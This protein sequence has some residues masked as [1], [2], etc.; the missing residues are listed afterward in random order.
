MVLDPDENAAA[1]DC[2]KS[3]LTSRIYIISQQQQTSLS[4]I[5]ETGRSAV[6]MMDAEGIDEKSMWLRALRPFY[7][8]AVTWPESRSLLT[9]LS[10]DQMRYH[11][12]S[13]SGGATT[14]SH[15]ASI[16]QSTFSPGLLTSRALNHKLD[17]S[18]DKVKSATKGV[19]RLLNVTSAAVSSAASTAASSASKRLDPLSTLSVLS[20]GG[21]PVGDGSRA[22]R[23]ASSRLSLKRTASLPRTGEILLAETV[24]DPNT[25]TTEKPQGS[26]STCEKALLKGV[27]A[28]RAEDNAIEKSDGD[29]MLSS[30]ELKAS[31]SLSSRTKRL[32]EKAQH[33]TT[34]D[35]SGEGRVSK[36]VG[37][38]LL[39]RPALKTALEAIDVVQSR[40]I[41]ERQ[42]WAESQKTCSDALAA[43]RED[44]G[45][46]CRRRTDEVILSSQ[47]QGIAT[48][49]LRRAELRENQF[50]TSF[51]SL[52]ARL[53]EAEN[54]GDGLYREWSATRR[55]LYE[56]ESL[57]QSCTMQ[58]ILVVQNLSKQTDELQ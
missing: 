37:R 55:A 1:S 8:S 19:I 53:E 54:R 39:D 47:L 49:F 57:L 51:S 31:V 36:R 11:V 5:S 32:S 41:N 14:D 10:Q 13:Q 38:P 48:R 6:W 16:H 33:D 29:S 42:S 26:E 23:R 22:A 9:R 7:V 46:S 52:A 40:L 50:A 43:L 4:S 25:I 2:E 12:E 56:Q 34:G 35:S 24:E 45:R 44:F 17:Q 27:V 20:A 15:A 18:L 3:S 21:G 28:I 30:L 58:H